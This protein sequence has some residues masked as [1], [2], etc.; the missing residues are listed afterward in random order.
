MKDPSRFLFTAADGSKISIV[1]MFAGY[2]QLILYH[3]MLYDTSVDGCVGCSFNMD[4]I[5]TLSHL[6][7]RNTTFAV[8]APA[9][10]DKIN[11]FRERMGW[12]F[13]FYS[14]K[15]TFTA[16]KDAGEDVTW[17]ED[18]V[19][20]LKDGD[21]VL[22]TVCFN[23]IGECHSRSLTYANL[24]PFLVYSTKHKIVVLSP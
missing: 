9:H 21:T 13:P 4:H 24:S 14:S 16:A 1:D 3:F 6:R 23:S 5:P 11:A 20:L 2:K 8:I 10:I 19:A 22:H 7:S 18:I 12:K 17:S 15:D